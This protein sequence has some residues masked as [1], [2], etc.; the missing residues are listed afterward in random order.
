MNLNECVNCNEEINYKKGKFTALKDC[1]HRI[2]SECLSNYNYSYLCPIDGNHIIQY[3][4]SSAH[5]L[6]TSTLKNLTRKNKAKADISE[7]T[8]NSNRSNSHDSI[9]SNQGRKEKTADLKENMEVGK[10][11]FYI[12]RSLINESGKSQH[13]CNLH[14]D[15]FLDIVCK[16]Q[17][18]QKLICLECIAF[19]NHSVE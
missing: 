17:K 15:Y 6:K 2:C 14:P 8:S 4:D 3:K 1:E 9:S 16:H 18:C 10:S 19:G 7:V 12:N 13:R 5:K 11:S